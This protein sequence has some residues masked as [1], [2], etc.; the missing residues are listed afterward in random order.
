MLIKSVLLAVLSF[1]ILEIPATGVPTNPA[2]TPLGSVLDAERAQLGADITFGG[3]TIYDG[4]R[5]ETQEDGILR[6]R[7]GKSQ[8][9]LGSST[10]AEVHRAPN[11]YVASLFRGTVIASSPEGQ[12]FELLANGARIRPVSAQEIVA[13]VTW[14]NSDELV[15]TSS[16]GAIQVLYDGHIKTIE[17]G[18]SVRMEIQ[19]E[20]S[21]PP[22]PTRQRSYKGVKYFL[23]VA[24]PV[25][26]AI[27][28]WRALESPSCPQP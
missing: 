17:A 18:S 8:M 9:D 26:T 3:A 16:H 11:G 6:V 27:G 2:S 1:T 15:L 14:V 22:G 5:L 21:D 28:I 24:A 10:T 4:D 7:L 19:T 23:M 25:G 12:T 13:Q 20:A